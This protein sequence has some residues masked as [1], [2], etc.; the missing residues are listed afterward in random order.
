MLNINNNTLILNA[1]GLYLSQNNIYFLTLRIP[2][3]TSICQLYM[4][5]EANIK[6]SK[7]SNVRKTR[8]GNQEWTKTNKTKNGR[9]QIKQRMDEDK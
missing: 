5:Y 1:V 9:R 4:L 2:T 8:R 7:K 6:Y 3:F